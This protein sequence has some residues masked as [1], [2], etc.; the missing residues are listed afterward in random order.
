M[1][2]TEPRWAGITSPSTTVVFIGPPMA[3]PNALPSVGG[4]LRS[5]TSHRV[6]SANNTR[7]T[8]AWAPV[9]GRHRRRTAEGTQGRAAVY[10]GHCPRHTTRIR[11]VE[12]FRVVSVWRQDYRPL[13]AAGPLEFGM[14]AG[15]SKGDRGRG[16]RRDRLVTTCVTRVSR[17]AAT[18]STPFLFTPR[19][20]NQR[21]TDAHHGTAALVGIFPN[22]LAA[23]YVSRGS[24]FAAA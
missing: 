24:T 1:A 20:Q 6:R 4:A 16:F 8:R 17:H 3:V 5:R 13:T 11:V 19:R 23:C 15:L 22:R 10:G 9:P 18:S 14:C 2:C 21:R 12:S 7:L